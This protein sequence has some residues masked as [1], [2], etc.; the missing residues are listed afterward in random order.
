MAGTVLG[1]ITRTQKLGPLPISLA[2]PPTATMRAD[3]LACRSVQRERAPRLAHRGRNCPRWY[4]SSRPPRSC[5]LVDG[6]KS[7]SGLNYRILAH[8]NLRPSFLPQ[9][10]FGSAFRQE[11]ASI[12]LDRQKAAG[13]DFGQ[14]TG[15]MQAR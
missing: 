14:T 3:A 6:P 10:L 4:R 8:R 7:R 13:R 15:V 1:A 2:G 12:I 11:Q 9:K 5:R